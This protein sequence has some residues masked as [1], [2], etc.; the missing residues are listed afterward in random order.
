[1]TVGHSWALELNMPVGHRPVGHSLALERH[2]LV[3]ERIRKLVLHIAVV[4]RIHSLAAHMQLVDIVV[5][6]KQVQVLRTLALEPHMQGQGQH[7]M[8]LGQHMLAPNN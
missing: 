4:L 3:E 5:V 1:M 8:G 7:R 2:T 6:D